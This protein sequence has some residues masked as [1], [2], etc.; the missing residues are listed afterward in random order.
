MPQPDSAENP[1]AS[2]RPV[3]LF[4]YKGRK[5]SIAPE[6]IRNFAAGQ[7]S[8]LSSSE[9]HRLKSHHELI[10]RSL[11]ARLS[12]F[13]R[14]EFTLELLGIDTLTLLKFGELAPPPRHMILFKVDPLRGMG[15]LDVPPPLGLAV[16][17]RMLG[18]KGFAVNPDRPLREV[19]MALINQMAQIAIKEWCSHWKNLEE[20][21]P[22]LLGRET[23][24]RFLQI[25]PMDEIFYVIKMEA[26]VG[27]CVE[28][29]Q[30][31]LP[32][33]MLDPLVRQ[34]SLE[35]EGNKRE[36]TLRE[37]GFLRWNPAYD[38]LN[39]PLTAEWRQLEIMTRDLL[40]FKV[41]DIISLDSNQINQVELCLAGLPKYQGRLGTS[42]SKSAI[43]I[44]HILQR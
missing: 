24:P 35:N 8:T 19:E 7:T 20:L 13:L 2:G 29:M 34:L 23:N 27:D 21:R 3:T 14:T 42:G 41:G 18:G 30:M 32:I 26:G 15:V 40:N 37:P 1:S 28:E 9:I 22:A 16:A 5:S 43:E 39:I 38:D 33:K 17:D 6:R 10:A 4:T 25:G 36:K 31:V 11:G 44:T 12:L